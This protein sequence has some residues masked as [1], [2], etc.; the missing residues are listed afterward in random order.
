MNKLPKL[1]YQELVVEAFKA[2][3][4][5]KNVTADKVGYGTGLGSKRLSLILNNKTGLR[6]DEYALICDELGMDGR[7]VYEA[8]RKLIKLNKDKTL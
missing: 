4:E 8:T 3:M 7:K 6:L 1:S 5:M 2:E